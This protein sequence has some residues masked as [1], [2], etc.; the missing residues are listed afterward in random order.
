MTSKYSVIQFV[1][2]AISGE[3]IN[4]GVIAFNE[5]K[6]SVRFLA[7]WARVRRFAGTDIAFLKDFAHE[8]EESISSQLALPGFKTIELLN[9]SLINKISSDWAN[10]VQLT[11][12]RASLKPFNELLD[13]ASKQFLMQPVHQEKAYRDRRS[14]AMIA[15]IIVREA[16]E[17]YA[18]K[19]QIAKL[20]HSQREIPGKYGPHV[21]DTV[22]ANGSAYMAIQS[23]SFEL[24][25]ATQLDQLVDAVAFQIF[26]VRQIDKKL[27]IGILA[28]PPKSQQSRSYKI[29]D[30]AQRT[31]KGL[32]AT[33]ITESEATT[34]VRE[35]VKGVPLHE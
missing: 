1:P 3:R 11:T 4:I 25:E 15:K 16:I 10:S 31:Y 22:V 7:N 28:L 2:N 21:F 26:D 19:E 5:E 20:I 14:A 30:R 29:Y 33:V 35:H 6:I 13:S 24:P 32:D 12:P 23:V 27:P 9:E 8:V 18:G 34:W 17:E